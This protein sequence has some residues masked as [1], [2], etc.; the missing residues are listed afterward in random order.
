M[1]VRVA[2]RLSGVRLIAVALITVVT[3][4]ATTVA[5]TAETAVESTVPMTAF[6]RYGQPGALRPALRLLL[7][8]LPLQWLCPHLRP[9]RLLRYPRL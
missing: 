1:V 3:T 5:T 2:H 7:L 6:S 8:R 4:V 9:L